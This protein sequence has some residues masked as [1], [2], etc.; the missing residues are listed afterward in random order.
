MGGNPFGSGVTVCVVQPG[1][2]IDPGGHLHP[3]LQHKPPP[4]VLLDGVVERAEPAAVLLDQRPDRV[5][6]G[7]D[8][9]L[10][11]LRPDVRQRLV[12]GVGVGAVGIDPVPEALGG[13]ERQ[14][15]VDLDLGAV[16]DARVELEQAPRPLDV[17]WV[18]P[19]LEHRQDPAERHHPL[20]KLL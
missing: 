1:V 15:G 18:D 13:L 16:P 7:L 5:E 2:A 6:V 11:I 12:D 8:R 9:G 10:R 4:E 3:A 20:A 19:R 14:N 17:A